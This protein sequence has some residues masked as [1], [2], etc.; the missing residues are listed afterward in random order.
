M[1]ETVN[2]RASMKFKSRASQILHSV[3]NANGSPSLQHLRKI[4][5][6]LTLCRGDRR[7]K[8]VARFGVI[9][10]V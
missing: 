3:V 7:G 1:E 9:R 10:R 6:A 8:F 2:A 5:V 4:C